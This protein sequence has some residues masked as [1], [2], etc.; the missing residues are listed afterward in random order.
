VRSFPRGQ[1]IL[2]LRHVRY[3]QNL[4]NHFLARH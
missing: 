4:N 2:W 1:F 3:D